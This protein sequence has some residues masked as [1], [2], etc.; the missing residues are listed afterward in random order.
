MFGWEFPP[1]NSGGLGTACEGLVRGLVEEGAEVTF[2]LPR[3]IPVTMPG[4]RFVFAEIPES[5]AGVGA[6]LSE[7]EHGKLYGGSLVEQVRLYA[8]AAREIAAQGEYDIIH[9]HDWLSFGAGIGAR[10]VIQKPLVV[11]VHA[12]EFDRTGGGVVN[13]EVYEIEREAVHQ[14]DGVVA[15]SNFTKNV[16]VEKYGAD[17]S[18]VMV[19]HNGID[20]RGVCAWSRSTEKKRPEDRAFSRTDHAPERSRLFSPRRKARA[21]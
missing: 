9:A 21:R 8:L 6:Y 19:V 17:P 10:D 12:T 13:Q 4:V 11:H 18:K 14:A 7:S 3:R 20:A 2:V 1:Y 5:R 15:V 16:L